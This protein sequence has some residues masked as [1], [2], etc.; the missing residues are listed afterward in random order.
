MDTNSTAESVAAFPN[1]CI[2]FLFMAVQP[3]NK[4]IW[5]KECRGRR[6]QCFNGSQQQMITHRCVIVL[7]DSQ[8]PK[9]TVIKQQLNA[10]TQLCMDHTVS[11]MD[12]FVGHLQ[13]PQMETL[14]AFVISNRMRWVHTGTIPLI[15]CNLAPHSRL[16][17]HLQ[18]FVWLLQISFLQKPRL[19]TAQFQWDAGTLLRSRVYYRSICMSQQLSP[20]K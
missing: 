11:H 18:T 9:A 17:S 12:I 20:L 19:L 7:I 4:V 16:C 10:P 3:W 5:E 8:L 6:H 15:T 13:I 14:V 1:Q 2:L